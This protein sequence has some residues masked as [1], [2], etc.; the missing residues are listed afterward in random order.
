M[1]SLLGGSGGG[2]TTALNE[3]SGSDL[4]G[5]TELSLASDVVGGGDSDLTTTV[6]ED[7]DQDQEEGSSLS[8]ETDTLI[9]PEP[10][11]LLLFGTGLLGGAFN[12]SRLRRFFG[13]VRSTVST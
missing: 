4:S 1:G 5:P 10:G 9:N 2:S 3:N 13:K 6:L 11:S 7:Q 12:R 8:E